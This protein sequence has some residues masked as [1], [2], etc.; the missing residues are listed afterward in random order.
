MRVDANVSVHK[1]D[2]PV[3]PYR[4]E[5]KNLN[6]LYAVR[7]AIAFETKRHVELFEAHPDWRTLELETRAFDATRLYVTGHSDAN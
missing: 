5:I 2:A 4:V 3:V 1:R 7:H 6:S